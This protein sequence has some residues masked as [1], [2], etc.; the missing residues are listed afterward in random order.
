MIFLVLKMCCLFSL[1]CDCS[2]DRIGQMLPC[3]KLTS[4]RMLVRRKSEEI[5]SRH[6]VYRFADDL[7]AQH[8][9]TQL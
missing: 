6:S 7:Q 8:S 9:T 5:Q 4:N 2:K 3:E 1:Y